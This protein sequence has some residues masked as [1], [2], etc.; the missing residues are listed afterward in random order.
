MLIFIGGSWGAIV[1][2]ATQFVD[3]K[4]LNQV[5]RIMPI[6]FLSL[7]RILLLTANPV[8]RTPRMPNIEA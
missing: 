4:S 3:G 2:N 5:F 6:A 8:I 1:K 7:A